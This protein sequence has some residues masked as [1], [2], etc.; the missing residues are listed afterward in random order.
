MSDVT[1]FWSLRFQ[2]HMSFIKL[3]ALIL[4]LVNG[5]QIIKQAMKLRRKWALVQKGAIDDQEPLIA[6]TR[7]FKQ[8][9]KRTLVPL[10]SAVAK[11]WLELV[12]HMLEELD[13]YERLTHQADPDQVTNLLHEIR[14]WSEEHAEAETFV[15]CQVP[16]LVNLK[17]PLTKSLLTTAGAKNKRIAAQLKRLRTMKSSTNAKN[18]FLSLSTVHMTNATAFLKDILPQL[19]MPPSSK[20]AVAALVRHEGAE[21]RWAHQRILHAKT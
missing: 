6:E 2:E 10:S 9:V 4:R 17:D 7:T 15:V 21:A 20:T 14:R 16:K 12:S 5:S 13:E 1:F 8:K 18:K 19:D 11:C 3:I